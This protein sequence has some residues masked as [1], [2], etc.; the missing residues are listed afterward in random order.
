MRL[1]RS[2][3]PWGF[4]CEVLVP[5]RGVGI[6][7]GRARVVT[8]GWELRYVGDRPRLVTAYIEDRRGEHMAYARHTI[9]EHDVVRFKDLIGTWPP[10]TSGTVVNTYPD[11]VLV[12][13]VDRS[14]GHTLGLV[15]APIELVEVTH[16]Q[17]RPRA[18]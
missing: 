18:A 17:G 2:K 9:E 5:V 7:Q 6:S 12:E 10:G 11:E 15:D 3:P 13:I 4:G 16:P 1:V 14:S 8:T